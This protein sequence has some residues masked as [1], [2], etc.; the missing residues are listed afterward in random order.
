V[1]WKN[2]M[3]KEQQDIVE[4]TVNAICIQDGTCEEIPSD[5]LE[6]LLKEDF[7]IPSPNSR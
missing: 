5:I 2:K 3:E 6:E 1:E 7:T 4:D